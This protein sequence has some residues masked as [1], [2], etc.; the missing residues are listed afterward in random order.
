M[1]AVTFHGAGDFRYSSVDPPNLQD[2]QDVL[3][4]VKEAAICGSDLHLYRGH[5]P[6][7]MPGT[8]VGHEF[9]GIVVEVGSGV[10]QFRSGDRVV[11]T[12]HVACGICLACRRG[13]YH[14]CAQ[15]GVLGYGMAFGNLGGSQAEF[16]RIPWGD[17][18]LRKIPDGLSDEKAIFCGDI[19]TTAFGAV[20]NARVTPGETVAVIGAGPVGQM[21]VMSALVMGAA[22]VLVIDLIPDRLAMAET[23]GA[24]AINSS[25]SN[26]VRRVFQETAGDGADVVIEAVGGSTTLELAF[27]LVRGGGRISAIG[28]TAESELKFPLMTALTRDLTFRI[29]LA[30]IHRDIDHTLALVANGRVDPTVVVSH[31]LPLSQASHGY[32]LFDQR[33]ATKVLLI[34]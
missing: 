32:Q 15:G 22:K 28:V 31:R 9:T 21:A 30:N 2:S 13:D 3:V 12:F 1:N 16:V 29:G 27:Q 34:P 20:K 33:Q 7:I 17:V 14:Q 18:N 26:P 5:I 10:R 19:L 6:G 4:Q 11:G 8:V 25:T 23:L 24:R